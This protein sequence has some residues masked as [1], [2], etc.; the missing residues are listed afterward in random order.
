MIA[1]T[2][3]PSARIAEPFTVLCLSPDAPT[4]TQVKVAAARPALSASTMKEI[5]LP[6]MQLQPRQSGFVWT[7]CRASIAP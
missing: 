4:K 7:E 5:T 3:M 1:K 6:M 2:V